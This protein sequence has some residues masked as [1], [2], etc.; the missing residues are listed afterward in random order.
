MGGSDVSAL[1]DA[2]PTCISCEFYVNNSTRHVG[3]LW[4]YSIDGLEKKVLLEAETYE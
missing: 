2:P 1:E 3:Y 4:E